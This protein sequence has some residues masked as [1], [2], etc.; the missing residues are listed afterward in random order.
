MHE[1]IKDFCKVA[2]ELKVMFKEN[3]ELIRELN[4]S[5]NNINIEVYG[6]NVLAAEESKDQFDPITSLYSTVAYNEKREPTFLIRPI[7]Y[8]ESCFREK[9]GTP[10]QRKIYLNYSKFMQN[11]SRENCIKKGD[12]S[13]K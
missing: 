13:C 3:F 12:S 6:Q 8:I 4:Y 1:T 11:D 2:N 7:G 10:R 9:F 5:K